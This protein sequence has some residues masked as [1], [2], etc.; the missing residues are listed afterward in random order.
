M[1]MTE[2]RAV[3][4]TYPNNY[5]VIKQLNW[6]EYGVSKSEVKK[7]YYNYIPNEHTISSQ[8]YITPIL[9]PT[10]FSFSIPCMTPSFA[11]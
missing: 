9:I 10:Y 11:Y 8:I 1:E 6:Y 3:I 4:I 7:Y 2:Y 5:Q